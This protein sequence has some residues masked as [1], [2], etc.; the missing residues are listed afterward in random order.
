MNKI[1][2]DNTDK[3]GPRFLV[4]RKE[5]INPANLSV[6]IFL[7]REDFVAEKQSYLLLKRKFSYLEK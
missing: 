2:V 7:V 5:V 1:L 3:K 6:I 4:D